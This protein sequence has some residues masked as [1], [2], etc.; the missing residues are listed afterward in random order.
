MTTEPSP[1]D[2]I[3]A[4]AE[5]QASLSDPFGDRDVTLALRGFDERSWQSVEAAWI[6]RL[7]KNDDAAAELAQA[8]GEAFVSARKAPGKGREPRKPLA[9]GEHQK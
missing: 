6:A 7:A 1:R 8:Y 2:S 4:F 9:S 3:V 5:V